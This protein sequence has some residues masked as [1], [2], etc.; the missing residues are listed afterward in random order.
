[1]IQLKVDVFQNGERNPH[2]QEFMR[3]RLK[4]QR[5]QVRKVHNRLK[6][7]EQ[8]AWQEISEH[9]QRSSGCKNFQS[10]ERIWRK[11]LQRKDAQRR[12][13]N[14]TLELQEAEIQ[15]SS[16]CRATGSR[17]GAAS[18]GDVQKHN[19]SCSIPSPRALHMKKRACAYNLKPCNC[20]TSNSKST[21]KLGF[22][23]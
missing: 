18:G 16:R 7:L 23:N 14:Q 10:R 3:R 9:A 11:Q 13:V 15:A 22:S 2:E 6:N 12:H 1:M 19:R 4:S 21:M 5:M 17:T 20:A 8:N